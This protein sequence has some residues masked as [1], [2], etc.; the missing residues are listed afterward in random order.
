MI[1]R[2]F[3]AKEPLAYRKT[4]NLLLFVTAYPR[5]RRESAHVFREL[6]RHV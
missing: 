1:A 2:M 3:L 5:A 4:A 6:C